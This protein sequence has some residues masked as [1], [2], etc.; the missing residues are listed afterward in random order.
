MYQRID[1]Y[2]WVRTDDVYPCVFQM[3]R[4]SSRLRTKRQTERQTVRQTVRQTERQYPG[5][6]LFDYAQM[7]AHSKRRIQEGRPA[8]LH[9]HTH[10][11]THTHKYA[12]AQG[13]TWIHVHT[14]VC[15][16]VQHSIRT[17]TRQYMRTLMSKH[18]RRCTRV[19]VDTYTHAYAEAELRCM[20]RQSARLTKLPQITWRYVLMYL[21]TIHVIMFGC[22]ECTGHIYIYIYI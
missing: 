4:T 11:H 10:T 8:F 22:I 18:T 1:R 19:A 5:T 6:C 16:K 2:K 20:W 3:F 17:H 7:R 15:S 13:I 9:T 21:G 12:H 14:C